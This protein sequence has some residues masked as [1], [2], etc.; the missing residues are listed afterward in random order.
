MEPLNEIFLLLIRYLLSFYCSMEYED[1]EL[2]L[3]YGVEDV[4]GNEYASGKTKR[5]R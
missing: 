1:S 5:R 2:E 4:S 3:A